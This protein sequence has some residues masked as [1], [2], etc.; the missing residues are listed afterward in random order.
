MQPIHQDMN[1]PEVQTFLSNQKSTTNFT[2]ILKKPD[3][4]E[5]EKILKN[6]Q[7]SF[8]FLDEHPDITYRLDHTSELI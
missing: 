7:E 6:V 3:G 5:E 1:A 4:T 2:F 8:N